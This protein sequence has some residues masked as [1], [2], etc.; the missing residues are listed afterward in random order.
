MKRRELDMAGDRNLLR[1]RAQELAR[2]EEEETVGER[3]ELV[4][5]R[6]A[7]ERFCFEGRWIREVIDA[8][9]ITE[10]PHTPPFIAGIILLRGRILSLVDLRVILHLP[11]SRREKEK[12]LVLSD[13]AM[14]F[15]LL[16]DSVEGV[17][18]CPAAEIKSY[19]GEYPT[20]PPGIL[21]GVLPGP[22]A[23]LDGERLLMERSLR[24]DHAGSGALPAWGRSATERK[25]PT[26]APAVPRR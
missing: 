3:L 9:A 4:E 12:A 5:F 16:A 14:E 18:F 10:V 23:F 2:R 22:V 8:A 20:A 17:F 7:N 25:R 15:G 21:R 24:V 13:G 1:R 11:D 26:A 19:T 6:V